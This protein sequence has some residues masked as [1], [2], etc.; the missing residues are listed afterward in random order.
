M[1][2]DGSFCTSEHHLQLFDSSKSL[3]ETVAAFLMAGFNRQ[4]PL[5]VVATP[6]HRELLTRKLE[7][8]GLNVREAMLASR[9]VIL[10][11]AQTLSKFMRQD[12]PSPEAFDEVVGSLVARLANGRRV[13]IYGEMVDVL[14]A[15]GKYRGAHQLE[16]LWNAL[17]RRESFTLFCGYASGHFGD[18][19]TARALSDICEAH[20]HLHRKKDDLLAEYLLD[21][22]DGESKGASPRT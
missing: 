7:G 10:D 14:A 3:A 12:T 13:C 11:A 18:P 4:E 8:A 17:G 1:R 15:Q 19:K 6:E 20:S 9:L 5:L 22:R 16:E 21:Q 2:T